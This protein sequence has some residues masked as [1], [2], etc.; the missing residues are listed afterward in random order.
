M[1]V[2]T[3]L[4]VLSVYT[5]AASHTRIAIKVVIVDPRRVIRKINTTNYTSTVGAWPQFA[6]F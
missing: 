3:Y 4:S 5:Y 1:A 6:P 2:G